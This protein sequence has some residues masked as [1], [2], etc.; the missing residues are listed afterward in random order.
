MTPDQL[1]T[2]AT[3]ALDTLFTGRRR[4]RK[5]HREQFPI[6]LRHD[7]Q[8]LA[9]SSAEATAK[10]NADLLKRLAAQRA[11]LLR[12]DEQNRALSGHVAELQAAV[13]AAVRGQALENNDLTASL[14]TDLTDALRDELTDTRRKLVAHVCQ[15]LPQRV[16]QP[17][18]PVPPQDAPAPPVKPKDAPAS[19][20][21]RAQ[22]ASGAATHIPGTPNGPK[23]AESSTEPRKAAK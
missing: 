7:A 3:A 20:S 19:R 18:A 22:G 23:A 11:D 6:A 4:D 2:N 15:P 16:R 8:L 17:A 1:T 12:A 13:A 10:V 21:R 14:R 9:D 5:H